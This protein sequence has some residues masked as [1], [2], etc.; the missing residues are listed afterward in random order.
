MDFKKSESESEKKRKELAIIYYELMN[1]IFLFNSTAHSVNQYLK[2]Y[3][4]LMITI[5]P[6]VLNEL[7]N[8]ISTNIDLFKSS[9][10]ILK[11]FETRLNWLQE[12]VKSAPQ[13]SWV[14]QGKI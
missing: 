10:L 14:M 12:K 5:E 6:D 2:K 9:Q 3:V 7:L 8:L 13:F 4:D 1:I 11:L